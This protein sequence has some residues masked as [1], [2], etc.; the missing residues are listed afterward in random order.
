MWL[1]LLVLACGGNAPPGPNSY[2]RDADGWL[3]FVDCDDNNAG[4]YPG[5]KETYYDGR[6]ANCDG[7][8]DYDRDGDGYRWDAHGGEDCDDG[9]PEINPD[10]VEVPYDGSDNDCDPSTSEADLDGDGSRHPTD[11][12]DTDPLSFP[13][14]VERLGDGIDQDCR[15]DGDGAELGAWPDLFTYPR[16]L[17][18]SA[19]A[20]R[21]V[22]A[23]AADRVQ[24]PDPNDP[25]RPDA[26]TPALFQVGM[27]ILDPV[28][29]EPEVVLFHGEDHTD[30]TQADIPTAV[31]VVG[32][33][34][35]LWFGLGRTAWRSQDPRASLRPYVRFGDIMVRQ[36][37]PTRILDV[38]VG[39]LTHVDVQLHP[40]GA[41]A[42]AGGEGG[43]TVFW[44]DVGLGEGLGGTATT[45]ASGGAIVTPD[46]VA[47]SC[48]T[49]GACL[50]WSLPADG[51][52]A[53]PQSLS[54][55]FRVLRT[56]DDLWLVQDD[57]F[58]VIVEGL[59]VPLEIF[60]DEEVKDADAV[61]VV[62]AD[63]TPWVIALAVVEDG[64]DDQVAIAFG[65]EDA[66]LLTTAFLQPTTTGVPS[67]VALWADAESVLVAATVQDFAGSDR[68]WLASYPWAD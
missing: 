68:L 35:V 66:G 51:P 57:A 1:L 36:N 45:D 55:V 53:D 61:R 21:P 50:E 3:S 54:G 63:G 19:F 39:E 62:R 28:A 9:D 48:A 20:G 59:S 12:D 34:D 29:A 60:P 47:W 49:G 65:P 24:E 67:G 26:G 33:D 41:L 4:I 46:G 52:P 43:L 44:G 14:A 32:D 5:A 22:L 23:L 10:G 6:D 30:G 56:H 38:A 11:C 58:G 27:A 17:R 8:D 18:S 15:G 42:S 2:D 7:A 31:D 37:G 16:S 13:G 40:D 25:D 64:F